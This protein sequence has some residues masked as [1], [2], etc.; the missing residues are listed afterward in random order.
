MVEHM[1]VLDLASLNSYADLMERSDILWRQ[2]HPENWE[3]KIGGVAFTKEGI[4]REIVWEFCEQQTSMRE[5][6]NKYLNRM[7]NL[8]QFLYFCRTLASD[9]GREVASFIKYQ[10]VWRDPISIFQPYWSAFFIP[11]PDGKSMLS[12]YETKADMPVFRNTRIL[13]VK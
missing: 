8:P 10:I 4:D 1:Q 9:E 3:E 11:H 12:V 5:V 6:R 13:L 2:W 7:T